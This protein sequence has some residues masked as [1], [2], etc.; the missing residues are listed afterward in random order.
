MTK[1]GHRQRVRVSDEVRTLCIHFQTNDLR[2][3]IGNVQGRSE[4]RHFKGT[5]N[6]CLIT[7]TRIESWT[8]ITRIHYSLMTTRGHCYS[9]LLT[10]LYG[11]IRY[12]YTHVYIDVIKGHCLSNTE[13]KKPKC[14][15]R[16]EVG[17]LHLL[18]RVHVTTTESQIPVRCE[19][20]TGTNRDHR[21]YGPV[22]K[23]TLG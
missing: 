4:K 22:F 11:K 16:K 9:L 2:V 1:V 23:V 17:F 5:E 18:G 15:D 6:V 14:Q 3:D 20:T 10:T 13:F 19:P 8:P 12:T 7:L 21:R